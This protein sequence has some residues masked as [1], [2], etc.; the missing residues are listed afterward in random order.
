MVLA[1]ALLGLTSSVR[2]DSWNETLAAARNE[3]ELVA[4]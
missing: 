4:V 1:L 2:A 3:G